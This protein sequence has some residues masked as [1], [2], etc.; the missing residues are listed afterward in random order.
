MA[1]PV[2]PVMR[3]P[4]R[5]S[6]FMVQRLI[7]VRRSFRCGVKSLSLLALGVATVH[8]SLQL[9]DSVTVIDGLRFFVVFIFVVGSGGCQV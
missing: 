3:P 8:P 1:V 6:D 9:P 2:M 7:A 5:D 4:Q